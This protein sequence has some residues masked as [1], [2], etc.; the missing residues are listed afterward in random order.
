MICKLIYWCDLTKITMT[1]PQEKKVV[2]GRRTWRSVNAHT[3][4]SI[5]DPLAISEPGGMW[6]CVAAAPW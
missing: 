4:R 5:Q 6:S 3:K 1:K 2:S